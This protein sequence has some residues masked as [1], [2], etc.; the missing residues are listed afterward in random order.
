MS[1]P[2][3]LY[4]LQLVDSQ[5]DQARQRLDE[6]EHILNDDARIQQ[7]RTAATGTATALRE[8]HKQLRMAEEITREH[9]R[10][11]TQTDTRL[12]G[13]KVRNPKELQDLQ[14]EAAALKRY[15]EV[16]EERQLEAMLAVEEAEEAQQR[17]QHQLDQTMADAHTLHASLKGER[18]Q[19]ER[20]V[21]RL[22]GE[23]EATA[24]TIS[25]DDLTLYDVLRQKRRGVAVALVAQK[26]CSACGATLNSALLQA[27]RSP[28]QI[29]YCDTCGRILYSG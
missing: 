1:Q 6:I 7:A 11:I 23:R 21:A 28:S 19:L 26:S 12:Y 18:S 24:H 29:S 3:K 14:N 22:S 4:R 20:T 13:G 10:K 27:A 25:A 16:L 15:L 17:A 5:L 9:R 8:A 2:F